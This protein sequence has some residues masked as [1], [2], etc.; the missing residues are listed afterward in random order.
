MLYLIS[1][2]VTSHHIPWSY[3]TS[4]SRLYLF[5]AAKRVLQREHDVAPA[6]KQ[7]LRQ[8]SAPPTHVSFS[9]YQLLEFSIIGSARACREARLPFTQQVYASRCVLHALPC[10]SSSRNAFLARGMRQERTRLGVPLA[11]GLLRGGRGPGAAGG[12]QLLVSAAK[13]PPYCICRASGNG[14]VM[15]NITSLLWGVLSNVLIRE[16]I[17]ACS[18]N[19][20]MARRSAAPTM[21]HPV[22]FRRP[23][24]H[25]PQ[26][27]CAARALAMC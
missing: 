5:G 17:G 14:S 15:L 9:T 10:S 8:V 2:P 13:R 25:T 27:A 21:A 6:A 26:R 16:A 22:R 19:A 24:A 20:P 7:R 1:F 4:C 3:L 18:P 12:P 11:T 23:W